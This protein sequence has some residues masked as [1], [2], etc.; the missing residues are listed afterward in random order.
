MSRNQKGKT[1]E[2]KSEKWD[3]PFQAFR[4]KNPGAS[5]AQFYAHRVA[6]KIAAGEA[7]TTLGGKIHEPKRSELGEIPFA[8]A[9]RDRF[10]AFRKMMHLEPRHRLIDYGC[11]SLRIGYHMMN[12]FDPGNYF[13]LDVTTDF[14]DIGKQL[15]GASLTERKPHLAAISPASIAEAKAFNADFVFSSAVAMHVHPDETKTYYGNLQ[16]L[17]A[18]PGAELFFGVHLSRKP[19]RF[20]PQGW[21]WPLEF[22]VK[23]LPKLRFAGKQAGGMLKFVRPA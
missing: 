6:K 10:Q 23:S 18:K 15:I 7:H 9:G 5:F 13:G 2:D 11:G 1:V 4:R 19:E 22:Y 21:S 16:E 14:I 20:A 17:T 8:E 12:Y 3:A